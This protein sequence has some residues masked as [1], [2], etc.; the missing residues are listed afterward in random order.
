MPWVRIDEEFPHHPKVVKAGPLGMAM[1]VAALCYCNRYLTD[2]FVPRSVAATLLDLDGLGMRMWMGEL[3]GGG[4]DATWQLV[5]GDLED[6][7]LWEK[8]EGGWRIHDYHDYQPSREHVLQVREVRKDAGRKGGQAKSKQVAK[9]PPSNGEANA[10]AKSYPVPV[11]VPVPPV[12]TTGSSVTDT[13]VGSNTVVEQVRPDAAQQRADEETIWHHY[14]NARGSIGLTTNLRFTP[15]RRDKIRTRLKAMPF[16][17]V[18]DAAWGWTRDPWP[19]RRHHCDATQ[20]FKTDE[21][22]EKFRDLWRQ[23]PP[24]IPSKHAMQ[25]MRTSVAMRAR[26]EEVNG[27]LRRVGDARGRAQHGLP[28]PAD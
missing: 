25:A 14:L 8:A 16:A 9:Q 17:D 21:Q 12:G 28:A 26:A 5:V 20:V 22:A 13:S 19:E 15:K 18:Q 11:P 2:G 6:A 3:A 24:Q 10:E 27:D 1:Q 7:G 23:G 4:E